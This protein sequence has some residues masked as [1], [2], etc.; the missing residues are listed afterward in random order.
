MK[1]LLFLI[2]L[3]LLPSI[4]F[5]AA[6]TMYVTP[7]GALAKDGSNWANA[8]GYAE[9]ETDIEGA[10][11]A[12]D[13]YY[14]AGGTYTLT[15][16]ISCAARDGTAAAPIKFIGVNS[17]TTNEP[18]VV[19]DWATGNNRPLFTD[20]TS[21]YNFDGA[22]YWQLFNLRMEGSDTAC[23]RTD[24]NSLMV[25][26][27]ATNDSG[28]AA[29]SAFTFTTQ[30]GAKFIN[31]EGISTNGVAFTLGTGSN[32]AILYCYAHD[33][34][35]GISAGGF[36]AVIAFNIVD[37][38]STVGIT[39]ATGKD[40]H[41]LI[42]NTIYNCVTGLSSTDNQMCLIMHN[43]FN[44]NATIGATFDALTDTNYDN[45]NNYEGNGTNP[46]ANLTQGAGDISV[47]PSFTNAAG[48][49]FS[50]STGSGCI[51]AGIDLLATGS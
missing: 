36:T 12:G 6:A 42:N 50:L 38:C 14:I 23:L 8:M 39:W 27:K 1:K 7:A 41:I 31:C 10:A 44:D 22:D 24:A 47:D 26:C 11:E 4:C 32:N 34:V 37:T 45:Y 17:G 51:D 19:A 9:F 33:S 16:D 21:S 28:T 2:T 15:S 48:G 25:N 35:T 40:F 30:A 46:P 20:T 13:I 18:P 49:D 29:R 43:I 3:L 5:G